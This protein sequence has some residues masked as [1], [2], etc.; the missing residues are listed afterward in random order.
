MIEIIVA[1]GLSGID[2][3][4]EAKKA[5]ADARPQAPK[6]RRRSRRITLRIFLGREQSRCLCLV[7]RSR[8][9]NVGQ[10][11]ALMRAFALKVGPRK[12]LD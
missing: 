5:R 10:A 8:M 6:N 2:V 7:R 11:P 12:E 1:R 4:D 3:R 9:G